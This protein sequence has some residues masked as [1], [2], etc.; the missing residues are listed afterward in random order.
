M[1]LTKLLSYLSSLT[2]LK[3]FLGALTVLDILYC[4]KCHSEKKYTV[5]DVDFYKK[6]A[7]SLCLPVDELSESVLIL[8]KFSTEFRL[9]QFYC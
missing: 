6:L 4:L 2:G 8:S 9:K 7:A 3:K 1:L 5:T